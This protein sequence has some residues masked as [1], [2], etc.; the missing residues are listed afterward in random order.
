MNLES[1]LAEW[2]G[3][4]LKHRKPSAVTVDP[5]YLPN[6]V[7]IQKKLESAGFVTH[8]WRMNDEFTV[9]YLNFSYKFAD[10]EDWN[11]TPHNFG[12]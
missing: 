1:R 11:M 5:K 10:G 12:L 2:A 8:L 9:G 3:W 4:V 6:V 7:S